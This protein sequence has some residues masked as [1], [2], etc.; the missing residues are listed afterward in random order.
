MRPNTTLMNFRL[1]II[2]KHEF[3]QR[4]QVNNISMSTQLNL[5]IQE[6]NKHNHP[7]TL[8]NDENINTSSSRM[9]AENWDHHK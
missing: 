5:L 8:T 1:P 3:K 4:C 2:L 9:I 7:E 6:F